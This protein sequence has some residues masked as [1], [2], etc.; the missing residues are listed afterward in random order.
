MKAGWPQCNTN[1]AL[2]VYTAFTNRF[3]GT[4]GITNT[5]FWRQAI[6]ASQE[7]QEGKSQAIKQTEPI[8]PSTNQ[9]SK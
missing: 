2:S 7:I 8:T 4:P 9:S 5:Y 6:Y 1:E 3:T